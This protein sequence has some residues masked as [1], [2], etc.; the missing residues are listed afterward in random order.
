MKEIAT[1]VLKSIW[2][3]MPIIIIILLI[4]AGTYLPDNWEF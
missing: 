4:W 2:V 1:K 3:L